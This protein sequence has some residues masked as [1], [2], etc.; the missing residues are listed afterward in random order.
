MPR[1][2]NLQDKAIFLSRR[3]CDHTD[4]PL[5]YFKLT[6]YNHVFAT[7]IHINNIHIR[8]Q[9]C[10]ATEVQYPLHLDASVSC[11][12]LKQL[13]PFPFIITLVAVSILHMFL[14]WLSTDRSATEANK[15]SRLD[16][17]AS[18]GSSGSGG[19]IQDMTS[20]QEAFGH[21]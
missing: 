13:I 3:T 10:W 2:N 21:V 1:A 16:G 14:M 19:N 11:A 12:I 20:A 5:C 9:S 6:A 8:D 4:L 15:G 7:Y 18:G 17:G